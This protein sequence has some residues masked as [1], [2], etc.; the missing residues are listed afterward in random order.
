MAGEEETGAAGAD[1]VA[2]ESGEAAAAEEQAAEVSETNGET[3]EAADGESAEDLDEVQVLRMAAEAARR[4][5]EHWRSS[6]DK[7]TGK[8]GQMTPRLRQLEAE[9]AR[10]GADEDEPRSPAS[11]TQAGDSEVL[12]ELRE[13]RRQAARSAVTE[14]LETINRQVPGLSTVE[15]EVT[16]YIQ[17]SEGLR[18]RI[19]NAQDLGDADGT[20]A[21]VRNAVFEALQNVT[22]ERKRKNDSKRGG[23]VEELRRQKKMATGAGA[24]AARSLSPAGSAKD[25]NDMSDAELRAEMKRAGR[26]GF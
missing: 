25:P 4:E 6:H 1:A 22:A 7:L 3:A 17:R 11:E 23:R 12:S 10:R 19:A 20:R 26:R 9:L 24:T 5:A 8:L 21:A 18:R 2:D 13:M 15:V 16:E 14:E